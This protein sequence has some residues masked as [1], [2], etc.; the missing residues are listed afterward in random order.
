MLL[1]NRI[2]TFDLNWM[3]LIQVVVGERSQTIVWLKMNE[4]HWV[5]IKLSRYSRPQDKWQTNQYNLIY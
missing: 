5:A 4:G 3:E 1:V 2:L